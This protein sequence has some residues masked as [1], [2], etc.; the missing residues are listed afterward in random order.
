MYDLDILDLG[1]VCGR[2]HYDD[3]TPPETPVMV[4]KNVD[5]AVRNYTA[6]LE[7]QGYDEPID[8]LLNY[9]L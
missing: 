2:V 6:R 1:Y 9:D 4:R 5:R 8:A 3:E 7:P